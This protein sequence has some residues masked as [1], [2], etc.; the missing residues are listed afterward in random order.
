MQYDKASEQPKIRVVIRKRPLNRK[1]AARGEQDVVE[2][3]HSNQVVVRE[4]KYAPL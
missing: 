3:L 1:E 2:V 4:Q